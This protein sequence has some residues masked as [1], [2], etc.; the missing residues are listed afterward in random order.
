MNITHAELLYRQLSTTRHLQSI[1]DEVAD[2]FNSGLDIAEKQDKLLELSKERNRRKNLLREH[3]EMI[4]GI[5]EA[6]KHET[7]TLEIR[8]L[9]NYGDSEHPRWKPKGCTYY[10]YECSFDDCPLLTAGELTEFLERDDT[11]ANDKCTTTTIGFEP[12]VP[13]GEEAFEIKRIGNNVITTRRV[14]RCFTDDYA[15]V[16]NIARYVKGRGMVQM[17]SAYVDSDMNLWVFDGEPR[18]VADEEL[19]LWNWD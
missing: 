6:E 11:Y 19:S 4:E 2:V 13:E 18:K 8:H 7:I 14:R 5:V 16:I 9:E 3:K 12:E 1:S 15:S 10:Y 17:D